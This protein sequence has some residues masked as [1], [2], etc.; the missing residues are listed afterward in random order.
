MMGVASRM[1]S[2]RGMNIIKCTV[3]ESQGNCKIFTKRH[4]SRDSK[5]KQKMPDLEIK[6]P[7]TLKHG[8]NDNLRVKDGQIRN[9]N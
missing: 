6:L 9:L 8:D 3:W 7:N 1:S 4:T 2:M 5:I